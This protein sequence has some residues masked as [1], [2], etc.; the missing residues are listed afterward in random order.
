MS[1]PG[2][3]RLQ[4][5]QNGIVSRTIFVLQRILETRAALHRSGDKEFAESV[6]NEICLVSVAL[7]RLL[8]NNSEL[9][10]QMLMDIY[11]ES[12]RGTRW[13]GCGRHE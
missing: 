9:N 8:A 3:T 11:R 6:T 2:K 10:G 12:Q 4:L 1:F 13:G 7:L 5:I